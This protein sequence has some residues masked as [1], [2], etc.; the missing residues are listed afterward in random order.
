MTGMSTVGLTAGLGTGDDRGRVNVRTARLWERRVVV[1]VWCI[2]S[3][4]EDF[5]G[6]V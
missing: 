6:E 1:L 3:V 5:I 4:R 2:I